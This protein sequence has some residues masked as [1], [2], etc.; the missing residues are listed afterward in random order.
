[1]Q[2]GALNESLSDIWGEY[3]DQTNGK[4]TDTAGVK[5]LMGEDVPGGAIRNMANPPA[6]GDPDRV[7]SGNYYCGLQDDGGVHWNSGVPNKAAYLMTD[8][9]SFNGKTVTAIGLE[10]TVRIW[11][12]MATQTL[13]SGGEFQDAYDLLPQACMDLAAGGFAGVTAADCQEVRDALDATQMNVQPAACASTEAPVCAAGEMPQYAYNENFENQ[14]VT[15]GRWGSGSAVGPNP[16]YYPQT[17]NPYNL[18][19]LHYASSGLWHLWGDNLDQLSDGW[20]EM[21]QGVTVPTNGKPYMRFR[22]AYEFEYDLSPTRY[23]DGGVVEYSANGGAWTDAAALFV[24]NGYDAAINS[25]YTP[26][27]PLKGRQAFVAASWGYQSSR[28]NLQNFKGQTIRFR[29]RVGADGDYAGWGWFIDD[30][31][32]YTCVTAPTPTPSPTSTPNTP[33]IAFKNS[34]LPPALIQPA[35]PAPVLYGSITSPS[36]AAATIS[37]GAVF[38][39]GATSQNK[40]VPVGSGEISFL[41]KAKPGAAPGT[42]YTLQVKLGG[43]TITKTGKVARVVRLPLLL[44]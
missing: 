43:V 5:W 40:P 21:T 12:R 16:W 25:P 39:D 9:G 44:K 41:V 8:G 20:M 38:D 13:V 29:F 1:M 11:Y 36:T 15:L 42:N 10:K 3:I 19:D 30:A 32:V 7:G 27:N 35:R 18:D 31:Q 24:N 26:Y 34:Y 37:G 28:L 17:S 33:W 23:Y 6:F 22:H 2:S 4:G 14:G